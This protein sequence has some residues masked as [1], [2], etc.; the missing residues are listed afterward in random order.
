MTPLVTASF[1]IISSAAS[2]PPVSDGAG[3]GPMII[4]VEPA[5]A[6]TSTG[7]ITLP[8]VS[9][10]STGQCGVALL[11]FNTVAARV[12]ALKP[13]DTKIMSIC[14]SFPSGR[15]SVD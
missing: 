8:T 14:A 2:M 5:F 12:A 11:S 1:L 15:L 9:G 10:S 6:G 13:F 3:A 7:T 4:S